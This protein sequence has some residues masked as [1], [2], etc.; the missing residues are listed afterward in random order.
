MVWL[1][2]DDENLKSGL[3]ELIEKREAEVNPK[4]EELESIKELINDADTKIDRLVSELSKYDDEIVLVAIRD[5][6]TTI[7]K[8]REVLEEGRLRLESELSQIVITEEMEEQIKTLAAKVR[9]K[10]PNATYEEK[11]RILDMLDVQ[12]VLDFGY[13]KDLQLEVKCE[14]PQPSN[15][16]FYQENDGVIIESRASRDLGVEFI[17]II[18]CKKV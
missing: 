16:T 4:L 17:G 15:A 13:E 1:L 6:I 18:F 3:K 7:S 5:K 8:N 9:T 12:I 14:I 10:L 2:S 11:R